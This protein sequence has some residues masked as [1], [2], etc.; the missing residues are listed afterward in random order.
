MARRQLNKTAGE[1]DSSADPIAPRIKEM[2]R[3]AQW[4]QA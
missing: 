2:K 4:P 1:P 3:L